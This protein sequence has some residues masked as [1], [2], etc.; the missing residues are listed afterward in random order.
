MSPTG[1]PL[2][3]HVYQ[4]ARTS[5]PFISSLRDDGPVVRIR[6]GPTPAYEVTQGTA[7]CA[8][9]LRQLTAGS[10]ATALRRATGD[11]H[12]RGRARQLARALADEDGVA[13]VPAA[14]DRLT[15]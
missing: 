4:L 8:V 2:I 14:P 12:H 9:P 15:S 11:P 10:L 3:G 1:L 5:L 7:P 6:I 13:P